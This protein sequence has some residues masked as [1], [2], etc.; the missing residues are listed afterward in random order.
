MHGYFKK[1][2]STTKEHVFFFT[3]YQKLMH[4]RPYMLLLFLLSIL[5]HPFTYFL[6]RKRKKIHTYT[7]RGL[8]NNVSTIKKMG[9]TQSGNVH[10]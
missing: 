4:L 7:S 6:Y 8:S 2:R 10:L 5:V 3:V 1:N 9:L